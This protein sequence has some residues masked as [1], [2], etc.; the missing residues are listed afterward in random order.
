MCEILKNHLCED[1]CG[2]INEYLLPS[3][4]EIKS[5]FN[6]VLG[7]INY[8]FEEYCEDELFCSTNYIDYEQESFL[9]VMFEHIN[10]RS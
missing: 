4:E 3:K 7:E 6:L 8:V 5:N 10:S 9:N 2:I 1:V